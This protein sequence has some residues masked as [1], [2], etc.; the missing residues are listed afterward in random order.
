M[1][2]MIT[3]I[4]ALALSLAAAA[5]AQVH[6]ASFAA[7]GQ[8]T[9]EQ[10]IDIDAAPACVWRQ[11]TDEAAIRASGVAMARVEL[12]GGGVLE[13]GFTAHPAPGETIRHRIIAYLP[14][15]LLL[16][17]NEAVPAGLPGADLYPSIVQVISLEPRAGGGTRLT[18]AHTGYG[19]GAGYDQLYAF[20][21][22][23]NPSFLLA[24]KAAC[25]GAAAKP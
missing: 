1:K 14:E 20:F 5:S 4:L 25:E 15:R 21:H 11:F 16:L 19:T 23:H 17:R 18:L 12:K 3:P 13:E 22:D 7:G 9:L 2:P 8:R 24:A 6:D 10:W